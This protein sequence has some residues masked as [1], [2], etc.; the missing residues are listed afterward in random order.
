MD[1]FEINDKDLYLVDS[2]TI[3]TIFKDIYIYI[4]I[5]ITNVK[6]IYDFANLIEG[7]KKALCSIEEQ[8]YL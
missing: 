1:L 2:A 3:H 5:Y 8:D 6:T 7:S 4:Y